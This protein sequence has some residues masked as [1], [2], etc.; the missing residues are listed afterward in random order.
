[1]VPEVSPYPIADY[2][3]PMQSLAIAL[4][5]LLLSAIAPFH[6]RQVDNAAADCYEQPQSGKSQHT[7]NCIFHNASCLWK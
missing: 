1:M 5:P 6:R 2:A 3:F 4:F 7:Q